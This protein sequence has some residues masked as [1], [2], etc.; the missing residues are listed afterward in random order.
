M[1]NVST[2]SATS[3]D[4]MIF[5]EEKLRRRKSID[6]LFVTSNTYIQSINES[7]NNVFYIRSRYSHKELI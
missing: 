7:T 4:I 2:Q 6:A 5:N 1:L 3:L